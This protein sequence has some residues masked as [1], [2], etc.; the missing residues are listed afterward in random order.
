MRKPVRVGLVGAGRIGTYHAESLALRIPQAELVAVADPAPGAAEKVAETYGAR[1]HADV[2]SMIDADDVDA[3][4]IASTARSHTDLVVA[5]AAAGKPVFCEKP[6]A[7]SLADADRAIDAAHDA[8]VPLQVGFNRRFAAGFSDAHDVVAAGGVGSVQL[9]RSLTRDP[10][11]ADPGGVPPWTIFRETLIHDFD[12]L[13]WLAAAAGGARPVEV[14]A[15]ADALV[16]PDFKDAG[17]LDTSIVTI[18]F[19]SGAMA[20]AE[21][22]FSATYGYDVRAEVFGSAGMVTAGEQAVGS[23]RHYSAQGLTRRTV[24]GDTALFGDAY[25]AELAHFVDCARTGA[26]PAVT[27]HDARAALAIALACITSVQE[28]R[29]VRL[30]EVAPA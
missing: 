10:G 23:M 9:L 2:R 19:D 6:M 18:R 24:R 13:L 11:L 20:T 14:Y 16:A 7:F 5:V 12:A 22:S 3:V 8:G 26:T 30:A 15:V 29:P 28:R 25:T 27:G 1:P 21:A 4:A 17:L